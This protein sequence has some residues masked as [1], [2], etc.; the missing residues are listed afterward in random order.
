MKK[1]RGEWKEGEVLLNVSEDGMQ[2]SVANPFANF[3]SVYCTEMY[4]LDILT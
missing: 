3:M 4:I 1:T 2:L